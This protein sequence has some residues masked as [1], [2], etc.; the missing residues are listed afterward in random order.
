MHTALHPVVTFE[1]RLVCCEGGKHFRTP[2]LEYTAQSLLHSCREGS[3]PTLP[4][5]VVRLTSV[6]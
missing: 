3:C 2:A 5:I 4:H 1:G 6:R